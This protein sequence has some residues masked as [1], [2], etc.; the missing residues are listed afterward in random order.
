LIACARSIWTDAV[1]P[2]ARI[3]EWEDRAIMARRFLGATTAIA[4]LAS[5]VVL[6][7]C[8]VQLVDPYDEVIDNGLMSFNQDFLQFMAGIEANV[9]REDA[10]YASNVSFYNEQQATIATLVQR[11]KASDPGGSCTGTAVTQ[12]AVQRVDAI[13]LPGDAKTDRPPPT[14]SC[15]TIL[16]TQ[17]QEQLTDTACFHQAIY[18]QTST[19]CEAR[20]FT[21]SIAQSL[22]NAPRATKQTLLGEVESAVTDSVTAAM[23]FE[24]A[25][26]QGVN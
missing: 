16:L 15:T 22:Q 20:G 6:V 24:L 3:K 4:W 26:K 17:I 9:P 11:A 1:E 14:G 5:V 25:E 7:A 12:G 2:P 18:G 8:A 19:E 23:T 21:A 13:V 10:S